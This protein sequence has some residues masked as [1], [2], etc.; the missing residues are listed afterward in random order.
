[1]SGVS[2]M[3]KTFIDTAWNSKKHVCYDPEKDIFFE[4]NSLA[5]LKDY[6]EIYLDS[7]IFPDMWTQLREVMNDG[8]KVYYF[9][10]PWKWKEIRKRFKEE[11]KAKTG[12]VSKTDKG[13]AFLLWKVYEL[14]L[15][16]RNTHRYFKPLTIIDIEL[17]PLLMRERI[18]YRNLQRVQKASMF[19]VDVGSDLKMLKK[20]VEDARREVVNRAIRLIPGFID[21]AKCL[22]LDRDDIN[23]LAGLAGLLVHNKS[24]SYKKSINYLG[25][26]KA[27]SI[28]GR[29]KR[30][31]SDRAQRYLTILANAVLW[32]NGEHRP[33][34]YRDMRKILKT[35]LQAWR[36]RGSPRGWGIGPGKTRTHL[37]VVLGEPKRLEARTVSIFLL[38]GSGYQTSPSP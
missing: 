17:R 1:L 8:K 25:L 19:D 38:G 9:T 35:V 32:K 3:S 15:T 20:M 16:K 12:K 18:L 6:D 29:R 13:D 36:Q 4:V 26:Y 34:R 5:E 21:I 7:S 23:G 33:A 37:K 10:R 11:L 31:Y 2:K 22:G 30:R 14:S 24:V 27:K 28:D